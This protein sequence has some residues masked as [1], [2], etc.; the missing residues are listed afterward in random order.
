MAGSKRRYQHSFKLTS[1]RRCPFVC[2]SCACMPALFL[3]PAAS[4][5]TITGYGIMRKGFN[6]S[7]LWGGIGGAGSAV[8]VS[9]LIDSTSLDPELPS[10]LMPAIPAPTLVPSPVH[11]SHTHT[12]IH[13][14]P[15]MHIHAPFRVAMRTPLTRI[16]LHLPSPACPRSVALR[17]RPRRACWL[18]RVAHPYPHPFPRCDTNPP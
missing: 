11:T 13:L 7:L 16:P 6:G 4:L 3:H 14:H 17:P 1:G 2:A 15:H 12:H 8:G 9:Q 5:Q 18:A 10:A